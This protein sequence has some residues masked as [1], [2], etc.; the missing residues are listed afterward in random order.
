VY[1]GAVGGGGCGDCKVIHIG[2][3]NALWDVG[4]EGRDI[5]DKKERGDG[6]ALGDAYFN[7]NMS[8]GSSFEE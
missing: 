7:R 1:V 6:R 3:S 4:V 8:K 5:D 2:D